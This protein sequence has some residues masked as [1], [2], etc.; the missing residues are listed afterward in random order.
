MPKDLLDLVQGAPAVDQETGELMPEVMDAQFGQAGLLPQ[1]L[2]HLVHIPEDR[3]GGTSSAVTA[4]NDLGQARMDSDGPRGGTQVMWA[5]PATIR[6]F[7][8]A[9]SEARL[10]SMSN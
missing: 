8:Q 4:I 3:V 7:R 6:V 9:D 10:P 2:P 1:P 5:S